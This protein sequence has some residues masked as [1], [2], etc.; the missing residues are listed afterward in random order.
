MF[1]PGDKLEY[2]HYTILRELG[3]GGMGVVYHCRDEFLQRE[4]AIKMMLP[5]LMT[6]DNDTA[7]IF[8]QEARLAAQLEHPNI[9]TIH[10][11]G[12]E[13]R[14]GNSYHYIA[15][16]YLPGGSLRERIGKE[17]IQLEQALEWMKQLSSALNYAHKRGVVHQDIKP[18]NVFIAQ[19]GNLKI[20]DFGLAL[21]ATGPAFDRHAEGKGTPAYVSP[22]LCRG[23]NRDHRSDIYS[24]GAVFFEL[25][26][27]ERPYKASSMVEMTMKHASAPVPSAVQL[28]PDIP[29]ALDR[30]IKLMM[31][32]K[33]EE[34][35]QSLADLLPILE[36]L[37]LEMKV[38]RLGVTLPQ[39][40]LF[41]G[42][43][44]PTVA[45]RPT[46][47]APVETIDCSPAAVQ[48]P[49]KAV[50][51]D[52]ALLVTVS[53]VEKRERKALDPQKERTLEQLWSFETGGPIGWLASPVLNR[54]RKHLYVSS[55]DGVLYA[56]DLVSGAYAWHFETGSPLL[57][58][59]LSLG[60]EI[61]CP[62]SDGT[63]YCL[64]ARDGK[65]IWKFNGA[66]PIVAN[67]VAS[68]DAVLVTAMDG[69]LKSLSR[70]DGS[71]NWVY[72]CDRAVVS[73]A[74]VVDTV[75]FVAS[76]DKGLHAIE[77]GKG[78]RKWIAEF[79]APLLSSVLT[80]TD[81]VYCASVEGKIM[82]VEIESGRTT[83]EYDSGSSFLCKGNLEFTSLNYCSKNGLVYCLDKYKGNLLW[84]SDASGP[85]LG[86]TTSSSGALYVSSRNGVLHSF[87]LKSG[88]L[89]W[90]TTIPAALETLPLVTSNA[91][92]QG[93]VSGELLAFALPGKGK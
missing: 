21:I 15:M 48:V 58:G 77:T 20:G 89:N 38:V 52:K 63:L 3:S 46:A 73:S 23:E 86:G 16:E 88:D 64:S 70:K 90:F 83:W 12:V 60:E 68:Q 7:Q 62:A 49:E 81:S 53:S 6:A 57:A 92:Y 26:T 71:V 76:K 67:P 47:Q 59:V 91:V 84:Q 45:A 32:K 5:E 66:S 9:V 82:A 65:V 40:S 41:G 11:I 29:A 1:T 78:Y 87:N 14:E 17:K 24:L 85:V 74:E 42:E 36:K 75:A 61:C 72:R 35:L 55:A 28:R 80:S 30:S 69:S 27:G 18:D 93:T 43:A 54:S 51:Q 13:N 37:L 10:N 25:L 22:E 31:A 79:G 8:R 34:R 4:I 44:Q 39:A 2:G 50:E 33:P 56:L 19:D